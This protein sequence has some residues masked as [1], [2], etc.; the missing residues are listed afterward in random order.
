MSSDG[1]GR[2][3]ARTVRSSCRRTSGGT[4][5]FAEDCAEL[6]EVPAPSAVDARSELVS[7]ELHG[8]DRALLRALVV[9]TGLTE[10]EVLRVALLGLAAPRVGF[11]GRGIR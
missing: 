9:R 8:T 5:P 7:V 10:G 3:N 1:C 2:S 6:P 4:V 11:T